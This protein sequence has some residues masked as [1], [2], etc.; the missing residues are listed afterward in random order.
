MLSVLV[1]D[2]DPNIRRVF[3][4]WLEKWNF[5]VTDAADAAAAL[6]SMFAQLPDIV[7]CDLTMPGQSGLWLMEQIRAS[8]P[9]MPIVVI[10]GADDV[11]VVTQTKQLG[12]VDYVTKPIGK[13]ALRQAL[14]RAVEKLPERN[15]GL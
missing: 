15:A 8:W 2:D 1:V 9:L 13:E 3:R 6:A 4:R 12:A 10:S 11:D 5:A 14:S 7:L